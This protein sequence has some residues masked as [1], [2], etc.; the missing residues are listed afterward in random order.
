M[1]F[2]IFLMILVFTNAGCQSNAS[3]LNKGSISL[4]ENKLDS[5]IDDSIYNAVFSISEVKKMANKIH[6]RDSRDKMLAY[7]MKRPEKG[8]GYYWIQV[9]RSDN[10]RVQPVYNFYLKRYPPDLLFLNT[11]NDSLITL[12]YWRQTRG[13]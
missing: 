12:K 8:F 4:G 2:R 6:K 9:G 7:I 5:L 13:W 10:S 3:K 11:L 1:C